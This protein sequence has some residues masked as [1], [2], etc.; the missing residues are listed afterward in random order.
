[1]CESSKTRPYITGCWGN[2]LSSIQQGVHILKGND[3]PAL[4]SPSPSL[5][6]RPIF[7]YEALPDIVLDTIAQNSNSASGIG[8]LALQAYLLHDGELLSARVL[9]EKKFMADLKNHSYI[10]VS[11]GRSG[12]KITKKVC[13]IC[14]AFRRCF[15]LFTPCTSFRA[16]SR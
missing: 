2:C 13:I 15:V 14:K 1:M 10:S 4:Q 8:R 9:W 5:A 7:S 6:E 3:G 16:S 11:Q 12:S